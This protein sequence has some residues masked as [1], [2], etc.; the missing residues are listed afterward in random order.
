MFFNSLREDGLVTLANMGIVF[1]EGNGGTIQEIFQDATQNYY[2]GENT[3]PT[4]MV[5]YNAGGYWDRSCSALSW[6]TDRPMDRRK[7]LLPLVKQLATEKRFVDA[8]FVADSPSSTVQF[9]V[10]SRRDRTV[11]KADIGLDNKIARKA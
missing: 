5:F 3:A 2:R 7:P 4:P 9:I 6:P 1:F 11:R 10:E 8:V